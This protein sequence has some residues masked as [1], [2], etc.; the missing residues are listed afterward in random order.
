M[1]TVCCPLLPDRLLC[2]LH[3]TSTEKH[4]T[5]QNGGYVRATAACLGQ[6][7]PQPTAN[8]QTRHLKAAAFRDLNARRDRPAGRVHQEGSARNGAEAKSP[9]SSC[10]TASEAGTPQ[11]HKYPE[12]PQRAVTA[13]PDPG[14]A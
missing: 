8:R 14:L 4:A 6:E 13:E 10:S 9:V 5:A 2:A 7:L 11:R 12:V 1:L 3:L